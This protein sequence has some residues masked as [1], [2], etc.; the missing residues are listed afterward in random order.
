MVGSLRRDQRAALV[1]SGLAAV[2]A[3]AW[4]VVG[5]GAP[6]RRA[7]LV[8]GVVSGRVSFFFI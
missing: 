5:G 1:L 2:A 7:G 8:G 4:I 3:L 6:P